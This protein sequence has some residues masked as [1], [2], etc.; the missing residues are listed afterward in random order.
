VGSNRSGIDP[1]AR[2]LLF[3][4]YDDAVTE[5]LANGGPSDPDRARQLR[6]RVK[7]IGLELWGGTRADR[8]KTGPRPNASIGALIRQV[9][10]ERLGGA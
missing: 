10:D 4:M 9:L 5:L 6:A 1:D 8:P 2:K 3:V 7:V